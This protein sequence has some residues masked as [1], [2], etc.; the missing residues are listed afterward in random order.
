MQLERQA[1][2]A[3]R[4]LATLGALE[5]GKVEELEARWAAL[6]GGADML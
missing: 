2:A 3:H 1:D 5:V 6:H 4:E